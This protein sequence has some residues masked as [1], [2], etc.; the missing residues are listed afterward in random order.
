[1][2]QSFPRSLPPISTTCALPSP[3]R[4]FL[5]EGK[6]LDGWHRYL[7]CLVKHVPPRLR[8]YAGE[9]GSPLSF[10]L[11][12]NIDRRHLTPGQRALVAAR[13]KPLFEEEARQRQRAPLKQGTQFP[14]GE[15]SPRRENPRQRADP[16]KSRGRS[17]PSGRILPDGKTR[18]KGPIR[19]ESGGADE[20]FRFQRQGGRPGSTSKACRNWS[21]P[22]RPHG[23]PDTMAKWQTRSIFN[24]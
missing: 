15:N 14:V 1:M 19:P 2:W 6:V 3:G 8:D 21:T 7:A 22:W 12:K 17:S 5:H 16:P 13:L 18:G 10:V 4:V 9:C 23:P 20:G 11:A 24:R